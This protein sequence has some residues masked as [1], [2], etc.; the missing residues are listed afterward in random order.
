MFKLNNDS[1]PTIGKNMEIKIICAR[2]KG[3]FDPEHKEYFCIDYDLCNG[4]DL[5]VMDN[6]SGPNNDYQD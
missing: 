6:G 5:Y 2:C 3:L 4:C 1:L